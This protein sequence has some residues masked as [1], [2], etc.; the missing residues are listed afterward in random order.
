MSTVLNNSIKYS[1]IYLI[2]I[3]V[4]FSFKVRELLNLL[5]RLKL[6]NL[7]EETTLS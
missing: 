3:K 2:S 7:I 5:N 1:L 4:L 6:D